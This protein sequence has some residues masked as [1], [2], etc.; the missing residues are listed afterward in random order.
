YTSIT[1]I[2][3]GLLCLLLKFVAR[4]DWFGKAVVVYGIL[5]LPFFIVN[6]IFTGMSLEEP[7]VWYNAHEHLGV[8]H[9]TTPVVHALYRFGLILMTI[10]FFKLFKKKEIGCER[11]NRL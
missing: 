4:I 11:P 6:G 2:S 7:V 1:F 5:L 10:Y 9:L 3:L 8:R